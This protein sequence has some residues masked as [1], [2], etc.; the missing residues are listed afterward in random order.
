[1]LWSCESLERV[2]DMLGRKFDTGNPAPAQK[3]V[4]RKPQDVL[5]DGPLAM[6]AD[7]VGY[8]MDVHEARLRQILRDGDMQMQRVGDVIRL[9]IPGAG[10]FATGSDRLSAQL[11]STL[12]RVTGVLVEFNRTV[13]TIEGHTD[14]RGDEAY[15]R[16]LSERRAKS[17]ARFMVDAGVDPRRLDEVG[18]GEVHP[19]A[20]NDSEAGRAANRRIEIVI[21]P[22]RRRS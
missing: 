11:E 13:I 1:M 14:D 20:D 7:E 18:R 5:A 2:D 17:V 3:P 21:E 6:A 19:V 4:A 15:N 12:R 9:S 10:I 22:L 8:F 16:S